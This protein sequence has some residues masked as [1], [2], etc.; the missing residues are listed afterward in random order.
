VCSSN[1][2]LAYWRGKI[3][4][5]TKDGRMVALDAK[6]GRVVWT[7]KF[8]IPGTNT[9]ST[10]A[11]RA[12][13]GVIIIGTS[14]SEFGGRGYVTAVDAESGHIS[15]RFFTVPG[16]PS[17]AF[18]DPALGMASETWSG[19]WWKYGGGGAVWNAI[20]Y[21][22]EL[23][24]VYLGTG[25]AGPWLDKLR[26]G[27]GK[28]NLFT[29]SIIALDAKTGHYQWHYQTTPD[30]VWDFD[31]T[32][33]LILATLK[34]DG[35][36][37]KVL[38]QANKNGFFYVID[39]VKGKLLAADKFAPVNW[40]TEVNLQTGRPV[41]VAGSR[42]P[43]QRTIITPSTAGAHDWQ[44][45]SYNPRTGLVYF[46][47]IRAVQDAVR[48]C[49]C[50]SAA[51]REGKNNQDVFVFLVLRSR[52]KSIAVT[53]IHP[54]DSRIHGTRRASGEPENRQSGDERVEIGSVHSVFWQTGAPVAAFLMN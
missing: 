43:E 31:A 48:K 51:S 45:M 29:A 17:N 36:R 37:R 10:G 2:G 49:R 12:L 19:E 18:E 42:Y 8:I 4:V 16:T 50:A 27:P 6:S 20:T 1:K 38:M 54:R 41:E 30:D 39:R 23:R 35:A 40:A 53:R 9:V 28:D 34:I 52:L 24:Q 25:N 15:W 21:D 33:D 3:Y 13:G 47:V 7:T 44:A 26:G 32:G 22:E 5:C 11:P 46:P 14:G